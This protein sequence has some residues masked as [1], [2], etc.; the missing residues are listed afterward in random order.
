MKVGDL[1][2][3]IDQ[4]G[5]HDVGVVVNILM[6]VPFRPGA[7]EVLWCDTG[8]VQEMYEDQLEVIA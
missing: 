1:V 6:H 3:H 8:I 4:T 7:L 5:C 2:Q